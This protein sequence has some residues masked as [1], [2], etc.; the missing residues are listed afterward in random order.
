MRA[1]P[2]P[3]W[4]RLRQ[5]IHLLAFV[6]AFAMLHGCHPSDSAAPEAPRA[7]ASAAPPDPAAAARGEYLFNAAGCLGCHTDKE[8][9]GARLAGG[10]AIPS[11]FGTFTS[12]NITPDP[13]YGIG[14]WS[15]EDFLHALRSG[16]SPSGERYFPAFP[17]T[18]FTLM[19]DRDIL[20]IRAYLFSQ[21]AQPA[22]S[23]APPRDVPFPFNVPFS[24]APWRVLYFSEGPWAPDPTRDATWNRGAYLVKAVGHCGE[25]H[26]PRNWLGAPDGA[27]AFNGNRLWGPGAKRAPNITPEARDGIGQW[28]VDDI[29]TLLKTGITP[30]GDVVAA[31]MADI[32]E[33][34]GK[35][36]DVDRR[37][38]A[39]YLKS[40]PALAGKGG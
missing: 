39:I 27:R 19:S 7:A 11:A 14:A 5:A 33:G 38:I 30:T 3:R 6:A 29:A 24:T 35:L 32:V 1:T 25:C 26:T 23:H 8:H 28:S 4:R 31:P 34:T 15:P 12:R 13:V 40:V 36:T 17:F 9:G 10:K 37:A 22:D 16:I 18:S 21:P 20:D 2:N